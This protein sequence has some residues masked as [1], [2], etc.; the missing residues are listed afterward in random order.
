M[1]KRKL[2]IKNT[3]IFVRKYP[4]LSNEKLAELFKMSITSVKNYAR[5][6]GLKKSLQYLSEVKKN[7]SQ[8][9][10]EARWKK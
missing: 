8:K 10:V 3:E 6:L 2:S 1:R 4:D 5:E 9:G 7:A